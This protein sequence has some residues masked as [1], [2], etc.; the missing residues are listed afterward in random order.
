MTTLTFLGAAGTVTG[1]KF[2][3]ER[4][5]HRILIDCGL[6]Q[7]DA[8]LAPAQL[9]SVP[10]EPGVTVDAVVLTHAH[11]DHCGYLPSLVR[12]RLPRPG[13][14]HPRDRGRRRDRAPRRRAP[15]GGGRRAR[16]EHGGYSRHDPPLPLFDSADAERAIGL[17]R[18]P[19][20]R[21]RSNCPAT[22]RVTLHRA[23]HILGSAFAVLEQDDRRLLVSGDLGRQEH[24][25]L[26][27]PELPPAV[28][29]ILV[30]A[31]YGDRQ[32]SNRSTTPSWPG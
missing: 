11:L 22:A 23:G 10:V 19:S 8:P 32:P 5:Q 28:D 21:R 3:L 25:L 16:R 13:D 12:R 4:D 18:P 14:L 31:T 15:P 7:G 27:P 29:T 6:F 2:L 30:E 26:L 9:G 1:S 17:F 20:V 24:P